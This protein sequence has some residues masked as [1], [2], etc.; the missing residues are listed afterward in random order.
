M[1]R[2]RICYASRDRVNQLVAS[3]ILYRQESARN[4]ML[5]IILT[6]VW[7]FLRKQIHQS[8]GNSLRS[9]RGQTNAGKWCKLTVLQIHVVT[10]S[11]FN[12][13]FAT[14]PYRYK[15]FYNKKPFGK[16]SCVRV[17]F[18][19]PRTHS[20]FGSKLD[21]CP[22]PSHGDENLSPSFFIAVIT[23]SAQLYMRHKHIITG[24]KGNIPIYFASVEWYFF[25]FGYLIGYT[26]GRFFT[27]F[28]LRAGE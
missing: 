5:L 9:R 11:H 8:N 7:F 18:L 27:I 6:D 17:K 19:D 25:I 28:R 24:E 15:V 21:L 16:L 22:I 20:R 23:R 3:Y 4:I 26:S 13:H 14:L 12:L 2:W 1:S 10:Q